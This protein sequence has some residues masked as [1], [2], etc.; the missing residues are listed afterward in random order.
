MQVAISDS[1]PRHATPLDHLP[2]ARQHDG[3]RDILMEKTV[4][5][6][7]ADSVEH[8]Y[9]EIWMMQETAQRLLQVRPLHEDA[10]LKNAMVEA[11]VVHARS[12]VKF[13]YGTEARADDIVSE[14]YVSDRA[15]WV[16]ARGAVPPILVV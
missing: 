3:G 13:I 15:A 10:V 14:D 5:K 7:R 4:E 9:Y 6:L 12:L 11:C 2:G 8:L 1:F 16:A